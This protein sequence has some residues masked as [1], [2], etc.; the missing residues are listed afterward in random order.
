MPSVIIVEDE[1]IAA[2]Y[3]KEVLVLNGFEVV[4]IID[5]GHDAIKKIPKESPDIVL[6]DIML[7]DN[8]SGSEVALY[9]KQYSPQTAI[10]FLTA[11]ADSEMVEYA[12]ESNS[13]GYLMKPYNEQEIV[14]SLKVIAAR[15][16][17]NKNKNRDINIV[18]INSELHFDL[19]LN[20]LFKNKQEVKLGKKAIK[21]VSLLMKQPNFTVSNQQISQYIWGTNKSSVTLRTLIH[22]I[23]TLVNSD[24]IHNVNGIGYMIK[25]DLI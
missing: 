10:I 24:F 6:M 3:L 22:R 9:L 25:I 8:I 11:Y 23:R 1:L 14:N 13:Y 20:K 4:D 19:N 12:V 7:K 2:E 15:V 21:L 17:Q 16:E 18:V 5:N